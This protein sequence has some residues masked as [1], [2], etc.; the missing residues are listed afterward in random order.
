MPKVDDGPESNLEA[1]AQALGE[2]FVG[3]QT[4]PN[5]TKLARLETLLKMPGSWCASWTLVNRHAKVVVV[6]GETEDGMVNI[7]D[8]E[9]GYP[10]MMDKEEFCKH[11]NGRIAIETSSALPANPAN[12]LSGGR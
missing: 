4:N 9:K 10:Y 11:W 12:H 5:Q 2:C 8:P 1:L 3:G 7:R 6:D